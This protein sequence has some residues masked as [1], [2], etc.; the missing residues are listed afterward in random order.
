MVSF[1]LVSS[2]RYFFFEIPLVFMAELSQGALVEST[3]DRRAKWSILQPALPTW[4][5]GEN[6]FSQNKIHKVF[7]LC[8]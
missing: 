6:T 8:V 1:V 2:L 3:L 5:R 7:F 4:L